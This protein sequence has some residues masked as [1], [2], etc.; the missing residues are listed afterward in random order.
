M[1]SCLGCVGV[2]CLLTV[3]YCLGISS[4]GSPLFHSF[5]LNACA[6]SNAAELGVIPD[7]GSWIGSKPVPLACWLVVTSDKGFYT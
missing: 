6:S 4:P 7:V 2:N 5:L 3:E 1:S